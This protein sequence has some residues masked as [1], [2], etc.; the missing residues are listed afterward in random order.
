MDTEI[1]TE[2]SIA[3]LLIRGQDNKDYQCVGVVIHEDSSTIR[4]AFNACNSEVKDYVDF[5]RNEIL[6][7]EYVKMEDVEVVR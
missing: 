2:N 1:S 4:I 3:H 7:I 5:N 6:K